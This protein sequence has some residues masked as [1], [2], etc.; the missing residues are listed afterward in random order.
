MQNWDQKI[1]KKAEL[2]TFSKAVKSLKR[3][4]LD[5]FVPIYKLMTENIS[6]DIEETKVEANVIFF[7]TNF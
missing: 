7:G 4:Q 1:H 5:A 2:N 3:L 6:I